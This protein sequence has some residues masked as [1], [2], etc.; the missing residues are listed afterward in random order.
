M[1]GRETRLHAALTVAAGHFD[2]AP[3][4]SHFRTD[5][6]E[7]PFW[8]NRAITSWFVRVRT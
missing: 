8:T 4:V 7:I 2:R 5:W 6:R 3:Q 1:T